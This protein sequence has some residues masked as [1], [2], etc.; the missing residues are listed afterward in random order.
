MPEKKLGERIRR[1]K[2]EGRAVTVKE[3]DVGRGPVSPHARKKGRHV[4]AYE[5]TADR[6]A[7]RKRPP[8]EGRGREPA[9]LSPRVER[10]GRPADSVPGSGARKSGYGRMGGLVQ[11]RKKAPSRMG[12]K[13][14]GGPRK[15]SRLRGG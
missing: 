15:R 7:R 8:G 14:K 2:R 9:A 10:P 12:V 11:G 3:S 6:N 5:R 1:A 13:Q 4:L